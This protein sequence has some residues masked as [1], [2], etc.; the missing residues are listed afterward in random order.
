MEA[1]GIRRQEFLPP[2]LLFRT[3]RYLLPDSGVTE[4]LIAV[5][6][7][8]EPCRSFEILRNN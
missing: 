1:A 7:C 3:N 2:A 8:V 5:L 6:T 4:G